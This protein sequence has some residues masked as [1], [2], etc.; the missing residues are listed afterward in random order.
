MSRKQQR[1]DRLKLAQ[2]RIARPQL[3]APEDVKSVLQAEANRPLQGG[4]RDLSADSLF[5]D[6]R[7]QIPLF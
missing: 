4:A 2:E 5:G 1:N 3:I 7:S 6:G